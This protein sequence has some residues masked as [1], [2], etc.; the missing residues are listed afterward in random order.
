[1]TQIQIALSIRM[2]LDGLQQLLSFL[3]V[4]VPDMPETA[5][6]W[7]IESLQRTSKGVV[8]ALSTV[9]V[10]PNGS[11]GNANLWVSVDVSGSLTGAPRASTEL[12][13][14]TLC[15]NHDS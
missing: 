2:A 3:G 7:M 9:P 5:I 4:E 1:M 10:D 6:T 15:R 14:V 13:K 12:I 11:G 8:P